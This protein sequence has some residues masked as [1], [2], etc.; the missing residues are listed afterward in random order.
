MLEQLWSH[1]VH[2]EKT[3]TSNL[4]EHCKRKTSLKSSKASLTLYTGKRH[5]VKTINKSQVKDAKLQYS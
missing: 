5:K 2:R 1:C 4:Y 3:P